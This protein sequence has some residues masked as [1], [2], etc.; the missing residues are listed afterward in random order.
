MA[1]A[2][3]G[4]FLLLTQTT[5]LHSQDRAAG[6]GIHKIKHVITIMQEN[7]SFDSYFGTFPGAD[8][9]PMR[10]GEPTVCVNDPAANKCIKPY[11][12]A[13]DQNGGGPHGGPA[14]KADVDGGKMDGFI[15]QAEKVRAAA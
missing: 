2:L 14:A 10:N 4:L 13:N 15:A 9:I 3:M 11:R 7:R 6:S 5:G 8:G 1:S 12:D